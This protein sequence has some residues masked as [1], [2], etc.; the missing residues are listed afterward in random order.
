MFGAKSA[1]TSMDIKQTTTII[2]TRVSL[3]V[4]A[5]ELVS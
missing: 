1:T 4:D 3:K 2:S 5:L